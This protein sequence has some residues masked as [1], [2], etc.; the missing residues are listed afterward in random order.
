MFSAAVG[1]RP[2]WSQGAE[3]AGAAFSEPG[4]AW[5]KPAEG[6]EPTDFPGGRPAGAS[7]TLEGNVEW[8]WEALR[9]SVQDSWAWLRA[10][11]VRGPAGTEQQARVARGSWKA[12]PGAAFDEAAM[13]GQQL[14]RASLGP[15][16]P[17]VIL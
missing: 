1:S 12:P 15:Q 7:L 10:L 13:M 14:V 17:Q 3:I 6:S 4:W 16:E 8:P 11:C 5:R 9:L 2:R